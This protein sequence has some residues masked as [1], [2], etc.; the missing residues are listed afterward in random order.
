VPDKFFFIGLPYVALFALIAGTI[1]RLKHDP[2]SQSA[3]SSQFLE[4]RKLLWGIIPFHL[5]LFII[6]ALHFI[7]LLMPGL[8]QSLIANGAVLLAVEALG[9]MAT[10]ACLLGLI[11]LGIRRLTEAKLQPVT[12][13]MDLVVLSLL[14]VQVIS[15]LMIA[16]GY[17]W[18]SQW[19]THTLVPYVWSLLTFQP[20]LDHVIEMSLII[21]LHIIGAWVTV[22]LIPFSRLIHMFSM[23]L[24]YVFRAPQRVVW[25]NIRRNA[26]S[27]DI[28]IAE[29]SSRRMFL[30]GAG[31]ASAAGALLAAGTTGTLVQFFRGPDMSI[32]EEAELLEKKLAQLKLNAEQRELQLERMRNKYVYVSQVAELEPRKG[33]YFIDYQMNPAMA[34]MGE[35]GLP[36]LISAKCTHLGC[37]VGNTADEQGRVL[38][39]CH[40]SYFNINDGSPNEGAPAKDPLP[41]LGWVLKNPAG[42]IVLSRGTDGK[43]EGQIAPEVLATCS[44][45]IAKQFEEEA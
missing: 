4:G 38:C 30:K 20:N 35:D 14:V 21:K 27:E 3:Q 5:G 45:Y 39:P 12:T 34:F 24:Q 1:Y 17:R 9:I 25:A 40:I 37:T 6:L 7:V 23:P 11:L 36:Q 32:E 31:G 16:L 41:R 28:R 26:V 2:F 10:L 18:G 19:A 29:V 44:V 8:W 22:L 13:T 33:K 42:E 43:L 15:G